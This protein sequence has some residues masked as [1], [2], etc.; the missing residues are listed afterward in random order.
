ME[1]IQLAFSFPK[2]IVTGQMLLY[3]NTEVMVRSPDRDTHFVDIVAGSL[4]G[5][6]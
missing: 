6:T 4:Q 2:E 1:Q 5:N 3:K